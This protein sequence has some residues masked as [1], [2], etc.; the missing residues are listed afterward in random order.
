MKDWSVLELYFNY[1]CYAFCKKVVIQKEPIEAFILC[2]VF[3][4]T[5]IQTF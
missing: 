2:I 3:L 1:L 5:E 4:S